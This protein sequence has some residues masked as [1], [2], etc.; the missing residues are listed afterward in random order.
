[1]KVED[2]SLGERSLWLSY[3][4]LYRLRKDVLHRVIIV[5]LDC[6]VPTGIHVRMGDYMHLK[7]LHRRNKIY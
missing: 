2:I 4:C 7:L 1:M 3:K 6:Q 5:L